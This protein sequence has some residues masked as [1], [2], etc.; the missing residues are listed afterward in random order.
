MKQANRI[1]L[2]GFLCLVLANL[3]LASSVKAEPQVRLTGLDWQVSGRR[4]EVVL[5]F[6]GKPPHYSVGTLDRPAQIY[7]DLPGVQAALKKNVR[8]TDSSA[9]TMLQAVQSKNGVRIVAF[10]DRKRKYRILSGKRSLRL[11]I[12]AAGSVN[13]RRITGIEFHRRKG[14]RGQVEIRFADQFPARPKIVAGKDGRLRVV[15]KDA[16]PDRNLIGRLDVSDF[17]TVVKS[18]TVGFDGRDTYLEI[19]PETRRYRYYSYQ[20]QNSLVVEV[21]PKAA[22][23]KRR[24]YGKPINMSFQDV[25]VRSVL[26]VF[27]E[28]TGLNIVASDSVGGNITLRLNNVPWR[29]AFEIILKS[30]G[31]DYRQLGNV[32]WVAPIDAIMEIERKELEHAAMQSKKAP[33]M[34]EVIQLNYARAEE[35]AEVLQGIQ[36]GGDEDRS[37]DTAGQ[38]VS[39]YAGNFSD[40]TATA[41]RF[42]GGKIL[43]ERGQVNVDKRTNI[44]I[45]KDTE[46]HL[47]AVRRLVEILDRPVRQVLVSSRIALTEDNFDRQIGVRL[48]A[49]KQ[50]SGGQGVQSIIGGVLGENNALVDLPLATP[51]GGA[52]IAIMKLNKFLMQLELTAMQKEGLV[53][54]IAMPEMVTRD[55]TE[56]TIE[57]GI[58]IPFATTSQNGTATQFKKAVLQ[59]KVKPHITP[60]DYIIMDLTVRKDSKGEQTQFGLA[61]NKREVRTTVRVKSGET[62]VLGGIEE[63]ESTKGVDKVPFFGDLPGIGHAFRRDAKNHSVK[64]LRIFITP[65]ILEDNLTREMEESGI[66]FQEN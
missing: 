21:Y 8:V 39:Q 41:D 60:D 54:L 55:N 23:G 30:K 14:R 44:L 28:F 4:I 57:Q 5:T 52:G 42:T 61:I 53:N 49:A 63:D 62:L 56:A 17:D 31:L 36:S 59:L 12:D 47:K 20:T 46:R 22:T 13:L 26:Q 29:Q 58:E 64:K 16:R 9:V 34:T 50:H 7:L 37:T 1:G 32:L 11:S 10:L 48:N 27:S 65:S 24:S 43:S 18:V 51:Y 45:V 3:L 66:A 15:F 33:L 6:D 40:E 25:P 19:V 38:G 2:P 35:V